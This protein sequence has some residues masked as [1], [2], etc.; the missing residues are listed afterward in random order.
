MSKLVILMVMGIKISYQ[1]LL[2]AQLLFLKMM[3]PQILHGVEEMLHQ[4]LLRPEELP[5][6]ILMVMGILIL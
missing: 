1:L 5:L 2:T 6:L 3:E 4:E